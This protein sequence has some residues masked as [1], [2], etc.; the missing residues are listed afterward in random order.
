MGKPPSGTNAPRKE[1]R[2]KKGRHSMNP[3]RPTEGLK[4]VSRPRTKGTIKRLQMYRCFK[5]KRNSIG[6]I[7]SPAPFQGWVPSG[8]RSRV[9]PNRKWFDNTRVISQ[10]ALQKFQEEF[11]KA[12]KNPY[13][14]IMKPTICQLHF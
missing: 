13:D 10:N 9:E 5:A 6:K 7:I 14:V 11:G 8:T 2:I 12:I 4:G 3:D 1:G